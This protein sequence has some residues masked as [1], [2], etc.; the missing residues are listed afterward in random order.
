MTQS[1]HNVVCNYVAEYTLR[2]SDHT[3]A[4]LY[5][6]L[7]TEAEQ[8]PPALCMLSWR[9]IG[10]GQYESHCCHTG[11]LLTRQA[12][13]ASPR[14]P[15]CRLHHIREAVLLPEGSLHASV[16][17]VAASRPQAPPQ[18]MRFWQVDAIK[19]CRLPEVNEVTIAGCARDA[20]HA[21]DTGRQEGYPSALF[22]S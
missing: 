19:Q 10:G 5:L 8:R 21:N 13:A 9:I 4:E 1:S 16:N 11:M 7:G 22:T 18:W 15:I 20:F 12:T 17:W 6:K 14:S 3:S 2:A